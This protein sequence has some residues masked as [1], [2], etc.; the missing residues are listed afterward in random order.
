[1]CV[2]IRCCGCVGGGALLRHHRSR[3]GVHHFVQLRCVL[4]KRGDALR[5]VGWEGSETWARRGS[6]GNASVN[7]LEVMQLTVWQKWKGAEKQIV[8]DC[9]TETK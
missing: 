7:R 1:V 4:S 8:V 6:S 3:G 9:P 2:F 5:R